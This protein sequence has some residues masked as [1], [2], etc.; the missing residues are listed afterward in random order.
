MNQDRRRNDF[1]KLKVTSQGSWHRHQKAEPI[2]T[3]GFTQFDRAIEGAARRG[4]DLPIAN[5]QKSCYHIIAPG[6]AANGTTRIVTLREKQELANENTSSNS[7][8]T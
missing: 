7:A 6:L 5:S 1:W 8:S 4:N 2:G 3:E